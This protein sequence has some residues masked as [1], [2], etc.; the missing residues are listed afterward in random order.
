[1]SDSKMQCPV[2]GKMFSTTLQVID[3]NGNPICPNCAQKAK[4]QTEKES[5]ENAKNK[6]E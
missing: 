5:K 2:C 6:T 1:M 4:L 3:D